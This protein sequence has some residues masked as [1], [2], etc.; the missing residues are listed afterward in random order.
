MGKRPE[1][2]VGQLVLA[3]EPWDKAASDEAPMADRASDRPEA[4]T[5]AQSLGAEPVLRPART[6]WV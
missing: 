2:D 1:R 6:N 3:I 5:G 4:S